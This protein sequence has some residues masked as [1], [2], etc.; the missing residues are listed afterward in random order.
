MIQLVT[1]LRKPSL[2][3]RRVGFGVLFS[4]AGLMAGPAVSQPVI[5]FD[6][7]VQVAPGVTPGVYQQNSTF[8]LGLSLTTA[9][10]TGG[11]SFDLQ[12]SVDGDAPSSGVELNLVGRDSTGN[13]AMPTFNSDLAAGDPTGLFSTATGED[14]GHLAFVPAPADTFFLATYEFAIGSLAPGQYRLAIRGVGDGDA[15]A[16]EFINDA[17]VDRNLAPSSY[18]FQVIPEPSVACL[19]IVPAAAVLVRRKRMS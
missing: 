16:S 19:F 11:T 14:L 15:V 10:T 7:E 2:L 4:V 9:F 8:F 12:F 5:S 17:D 3:T 1:P 13:T 18:V 6:D